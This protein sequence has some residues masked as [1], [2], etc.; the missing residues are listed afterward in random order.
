MSKPKISLCVMAY[1]RPKDLE[2][3]IESYLR[4]DFKD[5]E[6]V[7]IDD[8][9]PINLKRSIKKKLLADNRIRFIR[10]KTNLGY[11]RNFYKTLDV[12]EADSIVYLGDD[13]IFISNDALRR[14]V[15][16][17]SKQDIGLV[18]SKQILFKN[19][20]VDQV[21]DV[22]SGRPISVFKSGKS[23]LVNT[24]FPTTSIAGY[25]IKNDDSIRQLRTTIDSLFPQFELAGKIA[26]RYRTA[27][28]NDYLVGVQSHDNQL[29][30]I[31][32]RLN[33]VST[34][35]F[36]DLLSIYS[37]LR[38]QDHV[39][40]AQYSYR[41]FIRTTTQFLPLFLPYSK[42]RNGSMY[43]FGFARRLV[44]VNPVLLLS[45]TFIASIF[46]MILPTPILRK[47]L[48][49]YKSYKTRGRLDE[50]SLQIINSQ[51]R[52]YLK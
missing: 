42:I 44:Q 22:G 46:L 32:Y 16:A 49:I 52:K 30:P 1:N 35:I 6:M 8:A 18:I 34:N 39:S 12:C 17:F 14:Y 28:I 15:N 38:E 20:K 3:T 25:G 51:L 5:S 19:K 36:D 29:N 24:W 7:I 48:A 31:K 13:D 27:V 41:D 23:S 26:S 11:C 37:R 43:T 2:K 21:M 50:S 47:V 45:R 4:Q 9:S 10:N 33:G 40:E